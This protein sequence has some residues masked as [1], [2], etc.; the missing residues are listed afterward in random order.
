LHPPH[1]AAG[2][3]GLS[4]KSK[5]KITWKRF[6]KSWSYVLPFFRPHKWGI[7][8]V[9]VLTMIAASSESIGALSLGPGTK[10]FFS[11]DKAKMLVWLLPMFIIVL[12][13]YRGTFNFL[14]KYLLERICL[15]VLNDIQIGLFS[16]FIYLSLD[17]YERTT[18]GEMM[19]RTVADAAYMNRLVPIAIESFREIFKVFGLIGVCFYQQPKFTIYAM[20]AIPLTVVPV[21]RIS[22]KMKDYTKRSL[23]KVADINSILQETYAGAKVVRAF[24]MEKQE[25]Q[26]YTKE[27]NR[28]LKIYFRYAIAKHI[29]SPMI[30]VIASLGIALV[31]YIIMSNSYQE[32]IIHPNIQ[33]LLSKYSPFVAALIM[34]FEPVR[35]I[36]DL[37]GNFTSASGA[38]ERIQDT[39]EKQSTVTEP[40]DAVDIPPVRESIRYEHVN[41]KYIDDMV[42]EDFDLAIQKGELVALVGE[43]GAGKSTVVN[44]LPRFYDVTDGRIAIDGVDIK[45]ATLKSLRGQIGVV[46]QETFLFN[47]TAFNNIRYGSED[48]SED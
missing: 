48:K 13:L 45:K 11:P 12:F 47:N 1:A 16:H 28:L 3:L 43:S 24:A 35:R 30:G 23:K 39:F 6:K 22:R 42:L 9:I 46:T 8:L 29:I 41:F 36:G 27:M 4:K 15:K 5:D 2:G 14:S 20:I 21:Q 25:I 7:L 31:A 10:L 33:D 37:W 40:E 38:V 17:H 32:I 18:T 44:L 34:M 19:A 26:H